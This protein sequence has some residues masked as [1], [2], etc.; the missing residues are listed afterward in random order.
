MLVICRKRDTIDMMATPLVMIPWIGDDDYSD[1][2]CSDDDDASFL[3]DKG[4]N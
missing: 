4:C 2:E 1:D 3:Q